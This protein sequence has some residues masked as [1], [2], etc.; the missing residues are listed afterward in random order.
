MFAIALH[1][2]VEGLELSNKLR[3]SNVSCTAET[4]WNGGL[5]LVNYINGVSFFL[6]IC[7]TFLMLMPKQKKSKAN[8]C[9]IPSLW[10]FFFRIKL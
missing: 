10:D 7:A 8:V 5:S 1:S 4:P 6:L 3:T 2:L 9:L